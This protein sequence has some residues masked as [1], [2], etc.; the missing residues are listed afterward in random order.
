[1]GMLKLMGVQVL[2]SDRAVLKRRMAG[3]AEGRELKAPL[4]LALYNLVNLSC[5]GFKDDDP[6]L[7]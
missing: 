3:R 7:L 6:N 5:P 2:P 1:M 4:S